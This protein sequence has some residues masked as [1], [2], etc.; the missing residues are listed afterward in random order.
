MQSSTTV[1]L[2]ARLLPYIAYVILAFFPT[3]KLRSAEPDFEQEVWPIFESRCLDCHGAEEQSGEF[4]VDRLASLLAG[5]NSG[6]PAVVPGAVDRSFLLPVLR[7][8]IP[9]LQMPPEEEKLSEQEIAIIEK[10]I[11]QGAETPDRL[12]PAEESIELK[13][14]AFLPIERPDSNGVDSLLATKLQEQNLSFSPQAD[15]AT[16]IRRLYLVMLGFP[17]TPEQVAAFTRDERPDAWEQLIAEVLASPHYGERWAS[18][19]LDL[20]RF[21]ETHGFETN[22]ERTSWQYRDW[23]IQ[24]LNEDKPYNQFVRQQLAG[25]A[26]G[27]DLGTGFL[28]AGPYDLVKGQDPMLRQ[29]QRMNELDDMI[30]TTGTAFLGLS[31]G[32]ARCHNHKF[33]P[34][35]QKDYYALQ[36]VFAGVQHADRVVNPSNADRAEVAKLNTRKQQIENELQKYIPKP[37]VASIAID[38]EAAV[39]LVPPEGKG[40]APASDPA[41]ISRAG[42]TWWKNKPGTAVAAYR[43][44]IKG[45]YRIWLSWGTGFSSHTQDAQ[46][47]LQ[48]QIQDGQN[49]SESKRLVGQVNQQQD[50]SGQEKLDK[51]IRWSGQ[52]DAGVFDMQ[53]EDQ[54]VLQCGETSTAITADVVIFEP[55]DESQQEPSKRSFASWRPALNAKSNEEIFVP[56]LAKWIRF[57]ILNTNGAQACID[58]LEVFSQGENV[59]L[60]SLGAQATSGGDFVHPLHKLEHINDGLYGNPRSWIA[61]EKQGWVQI[62]LPEPKR[63]D[64]IVWARDREGKLKDRLAVDYRIEVATEKD[65]WQ[66]IA[67]SADRQP[68]R[69][70][71][72]PLAYDFDGFSQEEAQ[73]GR[74]LL[75][76]LSSV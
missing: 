31:T 62:E 73:K 66:T 14:W 57:Q 75:Q 25:D 10:W 50:A 24:S 22:R 35:S 59:A 34:I 16:L 4:R 45:K 7:H 42:Y 69:S 29:V 65:A 12:G 61:K 32:C 54:L 20:V 38:D 19:W 17:P 48:R 2:A 76:E 6:E 36:A 40:K 18:H 52:Y 51:T 70:D 44:N 27:Q 41:G 55:V 11:E 15:R 8:E 13:H 71:A 67:T 21:G 43:P 53:R 9:E 60:A 72:P 64:R 26:L 58:E 37:R 74:Q 49:R 5:G 39:H 47:V 28:V 30:N 3:A 23:V 63:I 1:R 56:R 46:Y 68:Y 33:D